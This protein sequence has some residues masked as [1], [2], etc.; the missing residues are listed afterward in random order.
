[1]AYIPPSKIK[2]RELQA[3]SQAFGIQIEKIVETAQRAETKR[4]AD[5]GSLSCMHIRIERED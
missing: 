1:M 2:S 4:C 5:C 3:I